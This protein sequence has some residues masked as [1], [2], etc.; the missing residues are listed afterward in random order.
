MKRNRFSGQGL[1]EYALILSLVG[2]VVLVVLS[3]LG[4]SIGH[5]FSN[6]TITLSGETPQVVPPPPPVG[7]WIFCSNEYE[8]CTV[9]GT[10]N[11]RYG[12]NEVFVTRVLSGT[13][14]CGNETFGDPLISVVKECD[15]WDPNANP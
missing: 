12:K 9:P 4:P 7:A 6:V 2:M 3:L 1:V 5:I 14:Y 13:F 15:Y 11:V 10:K 8:D